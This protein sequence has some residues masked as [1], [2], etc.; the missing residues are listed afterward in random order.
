MKLL[1][2][3][4]VYKSGGSREL[5]QSENRNRIVRGA[6]VIAF[7]ALSLMPSCSE[8]IPY[9]ET[10]TAPLLF[11]DVRIEADHIVDSTQILTPK[12]KSSLRLLAGRDE[13]SSAYA[14]IRFNDFTGLSSL[15]DSLISSIFVIRTE[16][17]L[18]YDSLNVHNHEIAVYLLSSD[19]HVN[20]AQDT[21]P[22][23]WSLEGFDR[24]LLGTFAYSNNDSIEIEIPN[25]VF[26]G[27]YDDWYNG[28]SLYN[29]GLLLQAAD[30]TEPLMQAFTSAENSYYA[31]A[32]IADFFYEGDTVS[33]TTYASEDIS[34]IRFFD[35]APDPGHSY[36]SKGQAYRS[37][38]K[39]DLTDALTDKNEIVGE[40]ILHLKVDTTQTFNYNENFYLYLTQLDSTEWYDEALTTS[41]SD[42]IATCSL[43]PGDGEAIFKI[44]YTV[45]QYMSTEQKNF[46][47]LLWSSPST[48]D[49]SVLSL[50]ASAQTDTARAPYLQV[51]TIKETN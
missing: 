37:F 39:I 1:R 36:V 22:D 6:L 18:P 26:R 35:I 49:L 43:K 23:T 5:L 8:Q 3:S 42:Y 51:I 25:S 33:T 19:S 10:N 9:E 12:L 15:V 47:F 11:S 41:T 4:R 48:L 21:F 7:A 38:L 24:E 17:E 44:S 20:W 31:P 2:L 14:L 46:G 50:Y 27:W 34:V 32:L 40:A 28:D 30:T 45:Q 29:Y 13:H 16:S